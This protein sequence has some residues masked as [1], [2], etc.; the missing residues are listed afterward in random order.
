MISWEALRRHDLCWWRGC[1]L[2][3]VPIEL[4]ID[5]DGPV[6]A[7]LCGLHAHIVASRLGRGLDIGLWTDPA[8]MPTLIP[9]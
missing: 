5:P 4:V 2:N 1:D 3:G 9:E 6:R 8:G 7:H